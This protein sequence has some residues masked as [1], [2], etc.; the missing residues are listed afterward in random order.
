MFIYRIPHNHQNLFLILN[1]STYKTFEKSYQFSFIQNELYPQQFYN[2]NILEL[3]S[4]HESR[5][6]FVYWK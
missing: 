3:C 1:F 4:L 6:F 2:P 5:T